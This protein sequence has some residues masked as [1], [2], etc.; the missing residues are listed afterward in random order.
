VVTG[1]VLD[2]RLVTGVGVRTIAMIA[3]RFAAPG[4]ARIVAVNGVICEVDGDW[5]EPV[6]VA[7][8]VSPAAVGELLDAVGEVAPMPLPIPLVTGSSMMKMV[9]EKP[10]NEACPLTAGLICNTTSIPAVGLL[11]NPVVPRFPMGD[12]T[13]GPTAAGTFP[14]GAIAGWSP[15]TDR[16]CRD[17]SDSA[18]K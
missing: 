5:P 1:I 12:G 15:V 16:S 11:A 2:P 4:A 8:L 14:T 13:T 10:L 6:L 3:A 7:E 9:S 17:S 18:Q